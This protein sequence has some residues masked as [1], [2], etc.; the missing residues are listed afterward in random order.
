[1]RLHEYAAETLRE[2]QEDTVKNGYDNEEEAEF[3]YSSVARN[4]TTYAYA[5]LV[6]DD[7][8]ENDSSAVSSVA[9]GVDTAR[10]TIAGTDK[11]IMSPIPDS[12]IQSNAAGERV[13]TLYNT[14]DQNDL[15]SVINDSN[16]L[17]NIGGGV[18]SAKDQIKLDPQSMKHVK[19]SAKEEEKDVKEA[20]EKVGELVGQL[21]SGTGLPAFVWLKMKKMMMSRMKL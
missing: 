3:Y 7:E 5:R 21:L 9:E 15:S 11:T 12:N 10:V 14:K 16:S 1:M 18:G 4:S 17:S 6:G 8:D 19:K 13:V 20:K 2:N